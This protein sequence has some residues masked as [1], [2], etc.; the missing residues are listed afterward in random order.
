MEIQKQHSK[1]KSENALWRS[2]FF[3]PV[4]VIALVV[5]IG[6]LCVGRYGIGP[7]EAVKILLSRII[8]ME[9]TWTPTMENV[10]F[11]IRLPRMLVA[12]MGGGA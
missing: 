7:L 3:I 9:S 8:P 11:R 2:H 5:C 1:R 10:V 4:C 6:S 12:A